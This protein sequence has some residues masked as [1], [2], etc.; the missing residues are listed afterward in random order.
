[1]AVV[2]MDGF[3]HYTLATEL[4]TKWDVASAGI[5]PQA[6]G[7]RINARYINLTGSGNVQKTITGNTTIIVGM[8]LRMTNMATGNEVLLRLKE[9]SNF[10]ID[11]ELNNTGGFIAS[12]GIS[13]EIGKSVHGLIRAGKWQYIEIKVVVADGTGGSVEIHIDGKQ[14]WNLTSVDT[15]D[16]GASGAVDLVTIF[17][18]GVGSDL[19][20][21][22]IADGSGSAPYNTILG[23]CR[24]DMVQ[25]DGD[26]NYTEFGTTT[27]TPHSG[28]VDEVGPDSD[29]TVVTSTGAN[30]RD[31]FTMANI[32]TITSQTIF[33][34]QQFSWAEHD[35]SATNFSM[36]FRISGTDYAGVSQALAASYGYFLENHDEDP[37][38]GPGAWVESVINGLESGIESL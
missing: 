13:T 20:D 3:Q 9:G 25:P 28:E 14:V 29:T 35:G 26:G 32:P 31:T 8:A 23:D 30:E 5:F 1:M 12:R 16:G 24:T 33:H 15:R 17:G 36:R 4:D 11:I 27:G 21:I 19:T 18:M 10:H 38:A 6:S 37:N 7:G 22:Y 2:F 34:V